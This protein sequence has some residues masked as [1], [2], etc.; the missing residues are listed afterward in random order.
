MPANYIGEIVSGYVDRYLLIFIDKKSH[1]NLQVNN[2][3]Y[4][5]LICKKS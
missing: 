3:E 5:A 1:A 4:K 2:V